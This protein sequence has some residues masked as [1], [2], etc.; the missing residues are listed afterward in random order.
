[1]ATENSI[2]NFGYYKRNRRTVGLLIDWLGTPYHNGIFTG[3]HDYLAEKD[4][5]FLCFITGRLDSDLESEKC[6]NIFFDFISGYNVD[7]LVVTPLSIGNISGKK[8]MWEI[9]KS[10]TYLPMVT[11]GESYENIPSIIID[12]EKGMR[13]LISHLIK[14]HGYQRFA[15]IKGQEGNKDADMRFNAFK[16]VLDEYK[17]PLDPRLIIEGDFRIDSGK[18]AIKKLVDEKHPDFDVIVS[19]NDVMALG[20]IE[21]LRARNMN[22]IGNIPLTG[23][24]DIEISQYCQLTTVKQPFYEQGRA[25]GE[26]IE[27]LLAGEK[28]E[29]LIVQEPELVIRMSCGCFSKKQTTVSKQNKPHLDDKNVQQDITFHKILLDYHLEEFTD[30]NESLIASL[31][32]DDEL[33]VIYKEFPQLGIDQCYISLYQDPEN[34]LSL[35]RLILAYDREKRF[36][37]E[38]KGIQFPTTSLL[39]P[40]ILSQKDRYSLMA[41]A[42]F[43][44]YEQIGFVLFGIGERELRMYEILRHAL[45]IAL[46]GAKLINSLKQYTENLE[47]QVISRTKELTLAN[48]QLEQEIVERKRIEQKLIQSEEHFKEVALLLPTIIFELD[49]RLR[50]SFINN[51]GY[52]ALGVKEE[53]PLQSQYFIDYIHEDDEEVVN[54]FC[55]KILKQKIT[56]YCEFRIINKVKKSIT[57]I[58]KANPIFVDGLIKGIRLSGIN[59]KP[60]LSSVVMPEDLFFEHYRFSPR[61]KEVLILM[62]QGYKTKEIAKKLFIAESTVKAHIRA[63]YTEV[64]VD[65]RTDFFKI[66][67]EYQVNHFGYH[68]YIYSILTKLIKE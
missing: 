12:N 35:S 37:I 41:Q 65:N 51:A 54:E 32:L 58:S 52:E 1:M 55:T 40:G 45:S 39:P 9:L 56:Q 62:L 49:L 18:L 25:A 28:V 23:F 6:R 21:I 11:L 24:D 20:V 31:E 60:F 10:Y 63:I 67:E 15:F 7:G 8:R 14:D 26:T 19:A 29:Q 4:L 2:Q 66:L 36:P 64:G 61:V 59:L 44:G 68:S 42:L 33:D 3:L 50:F 5:N 27:R 47:D 43:Q 57:I 38:D 17:I 48:T 16:R 30:I 34:P 46:K 13:W 22:F 53:E